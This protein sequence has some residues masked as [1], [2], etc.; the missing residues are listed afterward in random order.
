MFDHSSCSKKDERSAP[1]RSRSPEQSSGHRGRRSTAAAVVADGA[2][3]HVAAAWPLPGRVHL[4]GWAFQ[5]APRPAAVHSPGG[6]RTLCWCDGAAT[7]TVSITWKDTGCEKSLLISYGIHRR[8]QFA[9]EVN[10][11]HGSM[12]GWED[13]STHAGD[14]GV[15]TTS[16]WCRQLA[17]QSGGAQLFSIV[18]YQ[19]V[20]YFGLY[21]TR[22]A[23]SRTIGFAVLLAYVV[24][25]VLLAISRLHH[26]FS[27][28]MSFFMFLT[29]SL[30]Y[31]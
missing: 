17:Q 26:S 19:L 28:I 16:L 13:Y 22:S 24:F 12:Q 30:L 9:F 6:T 23:H 3:R 31:R 15:V 11:E 21:R 8:R 4:V 18:N 1:T 25:I 10:G 20:Q 27:C 5:Q 7:E 2:A 14:A 29:T